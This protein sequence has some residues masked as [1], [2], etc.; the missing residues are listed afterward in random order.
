MAE[1]SNFRL[2]S[3]TI[4]PRNISTMNRFSFC[5]I[6]LCLV[7]CDVAQ[8][9]FVNGPNA[10]IIK[11]GKPYRGIGVN[12]FDCFLRTLKDGGDTSYD[13]GFAVLADKRIPFVRFCCT[14]Y[15][16]ND[17][18]LY[19]KDRTEYFRRLDGVIRSAEKHGVGLIPSLFWYFACV[20][21][22]VGEPMDQWANPQ[23]KTQAFMRDYLREVLT[24]YRDSTA[25]WAWEFGNEFSL[26]ASL[27]NA[28]EH[29][30]PIHPTLGTPHS[31]SERD[32]LTFAM[33]RQAFI[34]FATEVRRDDPVRLLFTGDAFPR[35]AAWHL[36]NGRTWERDS[37]EQFGEMLTYLSPDPIRSISAH[38]YNDDDRRRFASALEVSR[39]LNKPLFVGEFGVPGNSPEQA[40]EFRLHLKAIFDQQI[41]LAAL[42]VLDCSEQQELTVTAT[43]S[44]SW[45]LDLIADANKSLRNDR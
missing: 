19:L 6:F 37:P 24:R 25:I 40:S 38:V 14:G 3:V 8:A 10:T 17:L 33:V 5:F 30:P 41:S 43:N 16:P 2:T 11:E 13:S 36:K 1:R 12:Y 45:Q 23:S 31:R 22:L 42:W 39:S 35:L 26:E 4:I 18:K 20:P 28:I 15:W 7:T 32:E 27:P 9:Q 44:R 29:R 34:S 21:D